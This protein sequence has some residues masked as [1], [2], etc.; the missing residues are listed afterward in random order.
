MA[1]FTVTALIAIITTVF[2]NRVPKEY[3][4]NV[5]NAMLWGGVLMLTIEHIAHEEIVPYPPFFTAGF[6]E[7]L[8]EILSIGVPMTLAIIAVW[9]IMVFVPRVVPQLAETHTAGIQE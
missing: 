4:I 2:R 6:S 8:P 9:G 1:C 3:R 7:M 5:L